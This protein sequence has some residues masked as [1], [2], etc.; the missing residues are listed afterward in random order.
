MPLF[1]QKNRFLL[2]AA[3]ISL[4][5]AFLH[6]SAP[7]RG[8]GESRFFWSTHAEGVSLTTIGR[9]NNDLPAR[10]GMSGE[11]HVLYQYLSDWIINRVANLIGRPPFEVQ[12]FY[13][14]FLSGALVLV[15][16]LSVFNFVGSAPV[17]L[18]SALMVALLSDPIRV[19][20]LYLLAG[21]SDTLYPKK[22][23]HVPAGAIALGTSQG[24]GYF[25]FIPAIISV[26]ISQWRGS[27]LY[28]VLAG[29]LFGLIAQISFLDS[30]RSSVGGRS[31]SCPRRYLAPC[32]P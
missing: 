12:A 1:I 31:W 24:L 7:L 3:L 16:Y 20:P 27:Y 4:L 25:L 18:V 10:D 8:A 13:G 30:S 2:L 23:F 26:F 21:E 19:D 28:A 11:F 17:A 29:L 14:A 5:L 9:W 22:I 6:V 15:V 32:D